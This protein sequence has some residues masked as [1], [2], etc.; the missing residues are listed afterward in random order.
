[1]IRRPPR[2]TLFP[3]T[4]LFRSSGASY[5]DYSQSYIRTFSNIATYQL[6]RNKFEGAILQVNL[7]NP[8][9]RFLAGTS[10][11]KVALSEEVRHSIKFTHGGKDYAVTADWVVDTS[12]RSKVLSRSVDLRRPHTIRHRSS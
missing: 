9:F 3:Y 11:L 5:E 4:T 2:S 8:N 10:A 1:M 6:D 12:G 7:E